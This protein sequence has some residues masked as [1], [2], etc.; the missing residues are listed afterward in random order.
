M[1]LACTHVG[2]MD[3]HVSPTG[4]SIDSVIAD[5]RSYKGGVA[6][7]ESITVWFDEG[8]YTISSPLVFTSSDSGS[9][10]YPITYKA[11]PNDSVKIIGGQH[12]IK[13]LGSSWLTFKDIEMSGTSDVTIVVEGAT[14]GLTFDALTI[15]DGDNNAISIRDG[16][17]LHAV[18]NSIIYNM[19][20]S[21]IWVTAGNRTTL[22]SGGMVVE[23]NEISNIGLTQVDA[24]A[25]GINGVGAIVRNNHLHHVPHFAIQIDGNN[26]LIEL[27]ELDHTNLQTTD[28]GAI[29]MGRSWVDRGNVIRYNHLHDIQPMV[30]GAV[31]GVY[32]DDQESGF[33]IHG[34]IFERVYR[35]VMLGGGRDNRITN[36]LFIDTGSGGAGQGA[37]IYIDGRGVG[38]HFNNQTQFEELVTMPY[39]KSPWKDQYPELLSILCDDPMEPLHNVIANNVFM[40]AGDV[41]VILGA[42]GKI[43]FV[44]NAY[45]L[46][47]LDANYQ[48]LFQG[49]PER[50][51]W[52]QIPFSDI[53]RH[54]PSVPPV[55]N[56]IFHKTFTNDLSEFSSSSASNGTIAWSPE[57]LNGTTGGVLYTRTSNSPNVYGNATG[58]VLNGLPASRTAFFFDASQLSMGANG[59]TAIIWYPRDSSG[60]SRL[61]SLRVTQINGQQVFQFQVLPDTDITSTQ[62]SIPDAQPA[63]VEIE[64]IRETSDGANDGEMRFYF[65][66]GDYPSA[67][68]LV[69]EFLNVQNYVDFNAVDRARLGI[70]FG[71]ALVTG[72]LKIDEVIVTS[73]AEP[74]IVGSGM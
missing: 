60:G 43:Q 25:I 46:F 52:E 39:S 41:S 10:E 35:G 72:T 32:L 1:L 3:F 36:N 12:T 63:W 71:S 48:V 18:K 4:P 74:I 31:M 40:G 2:A 21:G 64:T 56:L 14:T 19:G 62:N 6:P 68:I 34:N 9:Q 61:G 24:T 27:N 8:T 58:M 45:S 67:G 54:V 17:Y 73:D 7:T 55:E 20:R 47:T 26:H 11:N 65:G 33:V 44:N 37:R 51:A 16:G 29:Y 42:Q 15:H 66:G 38:Y 22:K 57:G 5:V 13:I 70:Q 50:I 53:G 30:G 23:N 59:G 69:A 28:S 49:H